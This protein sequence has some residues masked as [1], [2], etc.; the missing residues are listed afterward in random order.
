MNDDFANIR[1]LEETR[2]QLRKLARER[3]ISLSDI[4]QEALGEYV[5][6]RGDNYHNVIYNIEN[7][8]NGTGQFVTNA[9]PSGLILFIKSSL[10]YVHRPEIKYEVR[11]VQDDRTAVGR[12]NVVLRSQNIETIRNFAA[13]T[14]IWMELER[15]YLGRAGQLMY[16]TDTDYFGRHIYWPMAME[17]ISGQH[18]GEAISSYIHVFDE[19]LKHHFS[20]LGDAQTLEQLYLVRLKDG[21]LII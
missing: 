15:R 12:F 3:A 20:P 6:A 2:L 18:I 9:D 17:P 5:Y 11:I 13:F 16:R 1:I 14:R 7:A 8:L 21:K 19:L 4:V 10:R